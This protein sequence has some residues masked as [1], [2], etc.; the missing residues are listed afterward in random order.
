MLIFDFNNN[1]C[2]NNSRF[3]K[4][5]DSHEKIQIRDEYIT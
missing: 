1:L 3:Y 5:E 2:Y 4:K